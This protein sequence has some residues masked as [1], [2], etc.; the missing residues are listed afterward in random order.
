MKKNS[1]CP[2]DLH[3]NRAGETAQSHCGRPLF[4]LLSAVQIPQSD[5]ELEI[6]EETEN[7]YRKVFNFRPKKELT[8][9]TLH[10]LANHDFLK[11]SSAKS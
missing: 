7:R 3:P 6:A 1:Y 10:D 8:C 2:N 9:R 5:F 4:P 11:S